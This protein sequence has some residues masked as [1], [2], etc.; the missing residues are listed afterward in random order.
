M[1]TEN[2]SNAEATATEIQSDQVSEPK[3]DITPAPVADKEE[4]I[5]GVFNSEQDLDNATVS[6]DTK[7]ADYKAKQAEFTRLA[8]E[9]ANLERTSQQVPD[10]ANAEEVPQLDPTVVPALDS[11][12]GNRFE[13]MYAQRRENEKAQDFE[14]KHAVELK[15][16]LLRATTKDIIQEANAKGERIDQE[17]ALNQAKKELENRSKP[18]VTE[19]KEEGFKEGHELAKAKTQA[20]A[21]GSSRDKGTIDPSKLSAKEFAEYYNLPR[22]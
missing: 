2:N 3:S 12:L 11:W 6:L 5:A 17:A 15:D 21:V 9:K 13:G 8:Q 14:S 4:K 1:D 10:E 20:G 19:A 7:I 22:A 18:Q 16:R